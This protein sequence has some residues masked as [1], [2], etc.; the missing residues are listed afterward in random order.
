MRVDGK[1][2]QHEPAGV[3]FSSVRILRKGVW[4]KPAG[5][6]ATGQ[7]FLGC[8]GARVLKKMGLLKSMLFQTR[9]LNAFLPKMVR[10][11][12]HLGAHIAS[13]NGP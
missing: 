12:F 10:K 5:P 11:S 6:G 4:G 7:W 9:F 3:A 2:L 1:R 8:G 13:K